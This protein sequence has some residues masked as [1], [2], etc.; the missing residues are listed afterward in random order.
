MAKTEAAR[1]SEATRAMEEYLSG[2]GWG[3]AGLVE[4][5]F[6]AMKPLRGSLPS[7][8]K[9][10]PAGRGRC[11]T[12]LVYIG[13]ARAEEWSGMTVDAT[14]IMIAFIGRRW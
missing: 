14:P 9:Q 8:V 3:A 1:T 6:D 2:A 10:A 4:G 5:G 11:V 13:L 7:Y 12:Q